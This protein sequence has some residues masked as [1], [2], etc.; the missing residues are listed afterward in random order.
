MNDGP[1]RVVITGAGLI[2]PLGN[3][4]ETAWRR[5]LAGESGIAAITSSTPRACARI[6]AR[7]RGRPRGLHQKRAAHAELDSSRKPTGCRRGRSRRAGRASGPSCHRRRAGD[8]RAPSAFRARPARHEP[9][10]RHDDDPQHG[11]RG[12]SRCCGAFLMRLCT[13]PTRQR[14]AAPAGL[15]RARA[16][17]EDAARV[18][19]TVPPEA[20]R[21][22]RGGRRSYVRAESQPRPC[23]TPAPVRQRLVIRART[24]LARVR[25]RLRERPRD[26]HAGRRHRGDAR[27]RSRSVRGG[28]PSV[29]ET[30]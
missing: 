11:H 22:T 5:L 25:D 7:V 2:S 10:L 16:L 30:P 6:A 18:L 29:D 4:V 8:L 3:D 19:S 21:R 23:A 27:L 20:P 24:S 28:C 15:G 13:G 9:V 14:R 1:R 12:P 26:L 17:N